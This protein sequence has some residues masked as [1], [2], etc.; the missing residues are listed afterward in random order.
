[1]QSNEFYHNIEISNMEVK[2]NSNQKFQK[3]FN[4]L[5]HIFQN[6]GKHETEIH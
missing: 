1:M 2:L 5:Y 3:K 4:T 6:Q